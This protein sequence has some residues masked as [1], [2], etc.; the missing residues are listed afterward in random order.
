MNSVWLIGH[1]ESTPT[2]FFT[3]RGGAVL[4]YSDGCDNQEIEPY[5]ERSGQWP[6]TEEPRIGIGSLDRV[7]RGDATKHRRNNY[8]T[9]EGLIV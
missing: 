8:F 3:Q 7:Y 1:E 5:T 2:D 9:V 4:D 6:E